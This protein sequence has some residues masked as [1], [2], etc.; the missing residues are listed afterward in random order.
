MIGKLFLGIDNDSISY[1]HFGN[2]FD[3]LKTI[4]QSTTTKELALCLMINLKIFFF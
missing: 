4:P 1:C 2:V 3:T